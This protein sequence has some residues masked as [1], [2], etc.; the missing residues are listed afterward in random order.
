M[1]RITAAATGCAA[2]GRHSLHHP[3]RY[4]ITAA[5]MICAGCIPAL[6]DPAF[7]G[8]QGFGAEASGWRGGQIIAVTNL[9]DAGPG[10]LRACAEGKDSPRICIFDLSG[11][12][13]LERAIMVG[14]NIYIAGQTAPGGGIQLRL[15]RANHS[16]LTVKNA[17]DV[18]IRFLKLRPGPGGG[19]GNT[20]D[21]LTVENVTRGYFGNLSMAFA[22]DETFNIH[23]SNATARDITLADSLL[24]FSLDH[25]NHPKG[26]H[27][28]GALICST[29]G[30]VNDC[31]RITLL[32]NVFAHH[33]DRNP[34]LKATKIGPVDV[35]NNLFYDPISQFGEFYDLDGQTRINYVGNVAIS[36]PSSIDPPPPA[37]EVFDWVA[38]HPI[39][40]YV[41]DN[42]ARH[43]REDAP[44]PVLDEAAIKHEVRGPAPTLSAPAM[45]AAQVQDKVPQLVGDSLPDR[46]HRDELDKRALGDIS[47]CSGRVINHPDDVGGWPE[48]LAARSAPDSDGDGLPDAFERAHAGLDPDHPSDV[49]QVDPASGL[50]FV[51][52]WL[53]E[54]AGDLRA[55]P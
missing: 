11:T 4:V 23:V 8:A 43:C 27:S 31:G 53:A 48:P 16:P 38:D 33:R 46:S 34:D 7:P 14:S 24:A 41:R 51:E 47:R 15:D 17:H 54:L 25:A 10:S 39:E 50:P 1:C 26:R 20:V 3:L 55:E 37:V 49:W 5:A 45:A 52:L 22:T 12:I 18:V 29:E 6:A 30:S 40:V 35:I 9:D 42:L 2:M 21:A 19:D 13:T 32:R 44:I 36:G 28:K